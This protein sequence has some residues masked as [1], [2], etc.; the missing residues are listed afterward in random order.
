MMSNMTNVNIRMDA[1]LKSQVE[2]LLSELGLNMTTAIT[3]F[4]KKLVRE[5]KIP[6]EVS[7]VADEFYNPYNVMTLDKS[8]KRLNSGQGVVKTIQELED[9]EDE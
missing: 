2:D 7:A 6:F 5:R 8:I 1:N 3:I 9:M 4:A